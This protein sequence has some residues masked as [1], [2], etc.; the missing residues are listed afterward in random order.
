MP[1]NCWFLFQTYHIKDFKW[2]LHFRFGVALWKAILRKVYLEGPN[3]FEGHWRLQSWTLFLFNEHLEF[4]MIMFRVYVRRHGS[5]DLHASDALPLFF[6]I[7][8]VI[9]WSPRG[10]PCVSIVPWL[11]PVPTLF[12]YHLKCQLV[13]WQMA[14]CVWN[15]SDKYLRFQLLDRKWDWKLCWWTR[16]LRYA[17]PIVGTSNSTYNFD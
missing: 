13:P 16:N 5:R 11:F 1:F 10:N 14:T 6:S 12:F 3:T 7:V 8:F 9:H 2:H 15:F 4:W 17:A